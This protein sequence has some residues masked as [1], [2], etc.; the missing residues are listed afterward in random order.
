MRITYLHQYFNTPDMSGGTRS[1]EMARRLVAMGHEVNMVTSWREQDG[2]RAWFETVEAGIKLH[3][4]PV[5]YSNHMTYG[6]RIR[7][8]F[9]FAQHSARKTALIQADIVF[10]TST[11]LTIA[12][13]AVY[14]ARRQKVPMVFEVRDLWPEM[15]IA[16]GALKNPLLRRAGRALEKWA[17]R[18]SAAILALSPGMK[19]GVVAAGFYPERVAVIPNSSDNR[20][21]A[22]DEQSAQHF[23]AAR[24][25]LG[26]KPLL[27]YAG[28]FGKVNG[29]GYTVD[30]AK[31]L[32]D[33]G[34]NVRV[35]LV[36]DGAERDHIIQRAKQV[37]VF[38]WNLFVESKMPKNRIPSLFSAA[39]IAS[40]LFV[41][42][43]E[44]RANSANKFFDT[45][46][47]GKP[48]FMNYGGWMHDLVT[49]NQCGL[50]MWGKP[51]KE[52]AAELDWAMH[53]R[54]WLAKAG[55]AARKLAEVFFD[56]DKLAAQLEQV[57]I[58]VKEGRPDQAEQIAPGIYT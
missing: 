36:G 27:I 42:L 15:P 10:A 2:R 58:A 26:D 50:A 22:F 20:E 18:H 57:L 53:N 52:V 6:E 28:T 7:A 33:R 17:Y 24:P 45:L 25:W 38:E 4:L 37:G 35:L 3:W 43:P 29:V 32:K 21:F 40:S 47:A 16:M 31:A 48:I 51:I 49:S 1:Y 19:S 54:E 46:A 9:R 14:G 23:R 39:T 12:L 41:D 13:P 5:P 34:S 44:M 56:R 11:P 8:F 55:Q 30:L